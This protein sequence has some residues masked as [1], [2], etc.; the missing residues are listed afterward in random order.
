M[1]ARTAIGRAVVCFGLAV[2]AQAVPIH[3]T[4]LWHMHQPIYFPYESP[5]TIDSNNRF[6]FSVQ[7]VWDG[8]RYNCYRDWPAG[9]V[10]KAS[11]H[12]GSQMSYSG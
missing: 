11:G 6:N 1:K 4:H 12:G 7:G 8:D 5:G 3:V 9:A 10:A 2:T